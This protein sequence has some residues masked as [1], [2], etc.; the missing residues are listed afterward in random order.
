M[1]KKS[2]VLYFYTPD[3]SVVNGERNPIPPHL[4]QSRQVIAGIVK[5]KYIYFGKSTCMSTDQFVK[6]VGRS[7]AEGRA[8]ST[9]PMTK[10]EI[11]EKLKGASKTAQTGL[12]KFFMRQAKKLVTPAP[13]VELAIVT[14][15]VWRKVHN[16]KKLKGVRQ[17]SIGALAD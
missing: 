6:K 10:V 5:S 16:K 1:N 3:T 17:S 11:P 15:M 8:A 2:K 4:R 9:N 13:E 14:K 12:V 7:R